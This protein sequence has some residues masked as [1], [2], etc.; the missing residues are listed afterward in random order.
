MRVGG[1]ISSEL[2]MPSGRG[3]GDERYKEEEGHE[4]R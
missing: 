2:R 4:E 3:Q 1:R